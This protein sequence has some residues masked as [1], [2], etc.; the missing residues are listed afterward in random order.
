MDVIYLEK[1]NDSGFSVVHQYENLNT[2]KAL[3]EE[4]LF[5][6]FYVDQY[7]SVLNSWESEI[8]TILAMQLDV[9]N[10]LKNK[11]PALYVF[12]QQFIADKQRLQFLEKKLRYSE[13]ELKNQQLYLK[14][15]KTRMRQLRLTSFIKMNMK[16]CHYGINN[17]VIL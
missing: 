17:S 10:R 1:K 15:S 5:N 14:I 4:L 13:T 16:Y 9:E 6:N 11:H 2:L 3:Y 8:E 7:F 12:L